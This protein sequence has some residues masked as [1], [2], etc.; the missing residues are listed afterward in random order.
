MQAVINN[1]RC[2]TKLSSGLHLIRTYVSLLAPR[3]L[4]WETSEC[5]SLT[6][7]YFQSWSPSSSSLTATGNAVLAGE[8]VNECLQ[9]LPVVGRNV[10]PTV[11]AEPTKARAQFII[12]I[13]SQRFLDTGRHE[14]L[15]KM[16]FKTLLLIFLN[17]HSA[18][19]SSRCL[20]ASNYSNSSAAWRV[21]PRDLSGASQWIWQMR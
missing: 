14:S 5:Q 3:C 20:R 12:P 18:L 16:L 4:V 21:G 7:C 17:P 11:I 10:N 2:V 6:R 8:S 13:Q 19:E 1:Y 9:P 15:A